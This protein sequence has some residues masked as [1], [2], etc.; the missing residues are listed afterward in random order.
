MRPVIVETWAVYHKPMR[1]CPDGLRA[2]CSQDEW[3]A[4]DR[5]QPNACT[6]IQGD[7][8]SEGEAERLA[9]GKSGDKP[10]RGI[11]WKDVEEKVAVAG[12]VPPGKVS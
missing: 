11:Q 12:A 6:L 4:M 1:G 5:I 2:I 7:M 10:R 8:A 3:E 9:R